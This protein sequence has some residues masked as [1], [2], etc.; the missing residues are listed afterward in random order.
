[1]KRL[2]SGKVIRVLTVAL[3]LAAALGIMGIVRGGTPLPAVPCCCRAWA[4]ACTP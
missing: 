1:M 3:I 4:D 2:F